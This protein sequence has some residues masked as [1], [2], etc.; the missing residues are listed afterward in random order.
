MTRRISRLILAGLACA[1][2]AVGVNLGGPIE[3]QLPQ[4]SGVIE[5]FP[6][7]PEETIEQENPD[8]A[9]EQDQQSQSK[10]GQI[11]LTLAGLLV[12]FLIVQGARG[13]LQILSGAMRTRDK[14]P[15]SSGQGSQTDPSGQ[16][17]L[18]ELQRAV[19]LGQGFL[20]HT[21][22]SND[23]IIAAW[24]ALEEGAKLA[25]SPRDQAQTPTE[26]TLEVLSQTPATPQ[27]TQELLALYQVARFTNEE[28][29]QTARTRAMSIMTQLSADFSSEE[30]LDSAAGTTP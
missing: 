19:H 1:I 17:L 6:P 10:A 4:A 26:F 22:S 12:L 25:G 14:T 23:A 8:A 5:F 30:K 2:L 16:S 21:Q 24:L 11:I 3:V 20:T 27:V 15:R 18:P 28:L 29:D 7:P 13:A 9:T